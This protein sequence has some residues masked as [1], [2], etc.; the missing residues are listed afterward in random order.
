MRQWGEPCA[1]P[2]PRTATD[3]LISPDLILAAQ[4]RDLSHTYSA[5]NVYGVDVARS[6]TDE[7][8]IYRKRGGVVR[9]VLARAGINDTMLLAGEVASRIAFDGAHAV[10]DIIGIGAGVYDRLAEQGLNVTPFQAS[11]AAFRPNKFKNKRAEQYWAVRQLFIDG[12]IDVDTEDDELA[13]RAG[14]IKWKVDSAGRIQIE[15]KEDMKKRGVASPD[16]ADALVMACYRPP[17][18]P[19]EGVRPRKRSEGIMDD[20]LE[21]P[22]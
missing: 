20:I 17:W 15:S 9:H 1:R 19:V 8:A 10:V 4:H 5:S 6:G 14:A 12:E 13:T 7:S 22:W 3:T 18:W 11:E 16:R 21:I 2:L